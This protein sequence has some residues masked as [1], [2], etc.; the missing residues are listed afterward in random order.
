M[1]ATHLKCF[2]KGVQ[3][4]ADCFEIL[5]FQMIFSIDSFRDGLGD[6]KDIASNFDLIVYT[7]LSTS[8]LDLWSPTVQ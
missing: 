2:S 6:S 8:T 5:K 7:N 4:I 3:P 1:F